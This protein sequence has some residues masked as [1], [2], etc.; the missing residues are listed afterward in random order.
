MLEDTPTSRVYFSESWF[1]C[2]VF[3]SSCKKAFIS[4]RKGKIHIDRSQ[5]LQNLLN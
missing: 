4:S 5:T 1:D 2:I 3:L